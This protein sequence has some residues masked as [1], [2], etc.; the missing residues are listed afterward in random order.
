M[1]ST[2]SHPMY[3]SSVSY[4]KYHGFTIWLY[5]LNTPFL[6]GFLHHSGTYRGRRKPSY[7]CVY[8]KEAIN[9]EKGYVAEMS[10][11]FGARAGPSEEIKRAA[12][13][14]GADP[15]WIRRMVATGRAVIPCNPVH[16]P[17]P[18]AIGEGLTIKIN[19]NVGTSRDLPELEP[20]LEKARVA[21]RYGAD[22]IMDLRPVGMWTRYDAP[23]CGR[24]ACRWAPCPSIR[25]GCRPRGG[26]PWWTWTRMT[27]SGVSRSTP[28]TAWTS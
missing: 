6:P 7:P 15:E 16:S 5:K 22:A 12:K 23:Y 20:E 24:S 27:C 2:A 18:C 17:E 4:Y 25:R 19:A 3:R 10:I 8:E 13:A 14:E 21:V 26:V 9:G 28:A 11:M 1:S